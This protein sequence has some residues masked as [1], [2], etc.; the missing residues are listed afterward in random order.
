MERYAGA[1]GVKKGALVEQALLHLAHRMAKDTGCIG[2]VVDA[3]PEAVACYEK[4]GFIALEVNSGQLGDRP[5]PMPVFLDLG[6]I[7]Q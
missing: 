5:E 2:V 3:K 4:L 1:H 7:P 6:A